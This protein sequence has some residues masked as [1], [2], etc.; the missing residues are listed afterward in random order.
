MRVRITV[1]PCCKKAVD[2][3]PGM[4]LAKEK[5]KIAVIHPNEIDGNS[6]YDYAHYLG[7]LEM[8]R[9]VGLADSQIIRKL[10]VF[11]NEPAVM[12]E[13]DVA[14]ALI[15]K[16]CDI[17]AEHCNT[18]AAQ[19][20][21]QKA[22]VWGI[23]FNSDMS[24]DAPDA[25]ITSVIPHWGAFYTQLVENVIDGT[26]S[27]GP[28]F[29]GL[30]EGA[31]DITPINEK[32]AEPG[33]GAAADAGRRRIIDKGFNVFDGALKTSS[34]KIIGEEGKILSDEVSLG[35]IDWYY[36]NVTVMK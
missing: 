7:T 15:A 12:G 17:I 26:F 9:N 14:N 5:I 18:P 16:G 4:P 36:R 2:W 29:Y 20:A 22:G 13:T 3:E 30:A 23:G 10:N 31:V 21:A 34:G 25:V 11:D 32:I 33:T 27:P 24:A 6:I 28:H 8:Q 19:I 35:G 1:F